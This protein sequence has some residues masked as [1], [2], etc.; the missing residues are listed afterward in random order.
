MSGEL[1]VWSG[2][3][4]RPAVSTLIS[5]LAPPSASVSPWVRRVSWVLRYPIL[6]PLHPASFLLS[7]PS[8]LPTT[9]LT[10]PSAAGWV[11]IPAHTDPGSQLWPTCSGS[12]REESPGSAVTWPECIFPKQSHYLQ[13]V[14]CCRRRCFGVLL[15]H[16]SPPG[17]EAPSSSHS[18]MHQDCLSPCGCVAPYLPIHRSVSAQSG[19]QGLQVSKTPHQLPE[20]QT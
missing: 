13:L 3:D 16:W 19:I 5:D 14:Y 17:L 15:G 1:S 20:A 9:Y 10:R 4:L 2:L 7:H 6:Y 12:G 18:S 11:D 8:A